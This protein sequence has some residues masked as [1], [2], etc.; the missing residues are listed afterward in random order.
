MQ[1]VAHIIVEGRFVLPEQVVLNL[2]PQTELV[3]TR[4]SKKIY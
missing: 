4:T 3:K 1:F 2:G